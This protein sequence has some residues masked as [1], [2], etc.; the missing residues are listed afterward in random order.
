[1]IGRS[2]RMDFENYLAEDLL[3]K[4]DRASMANSL[5]NKGSNVGC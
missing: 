4:V 1:M 3:V 5:E 2:T